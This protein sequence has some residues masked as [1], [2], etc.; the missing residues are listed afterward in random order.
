[1]SFFFFFQKTMYW[2]NQIVNINNIL[3]IIICKK[4]LIKNI[5]NFS[6]LVFS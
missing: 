1:M 5:I 4:I 3:N 6:I 2:N